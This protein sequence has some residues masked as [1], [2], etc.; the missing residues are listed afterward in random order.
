MGMNIGQFEEQLQS[1]RARRAQVDAELAGMQPELAR[2][3]AALIEASAIFDAAL[4]ERL[5]TEQ[6]AAGNALPAEGAEWTPG[7]PPSE[8]EQRMAREARAA[9]DQT[10]EQLAAV[11]VRHTDISVHRSALRMEGRHLDDRLAQVEAELERAKQA[12]AESR[13]MLADVRR[14]LGLGAA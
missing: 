13:D 4:A 10:D 14:R 11:R 5:R 12:Q 9:W 8:A 1:L 7:R 3:E 6:A 2:A